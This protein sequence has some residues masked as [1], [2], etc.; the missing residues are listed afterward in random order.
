M[1]HT[2]DPLSEGGS[3]SKEKENI[4][5]RTK[6][7]EKARKRSVKATL[8]IARQTSSFIKWKFTFAA[9]AAA[10]ALLPVALRRQAFLQ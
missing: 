4:E 9:P 8:W 10:T 1:I 7:S 5:C 6:L 2:I 3:Q